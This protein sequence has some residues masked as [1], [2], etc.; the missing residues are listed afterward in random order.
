M[1][2]T[3]KELGLDKIISAKPCRVRDI[4]IAVIIARICRPDSKLAMTR[5]WEDTTLPE[6]LNLDG[7]IEG[8]IYEAMDWLLE[9][10][11]RIEK[12]LAK[13]HLK[14]GDMVLYDLTSSYFEGVNC[15]LAKM[16]K[17]RDRKRN[18]LQVNYGLVADRNGCPVSVS[19]FEGNTGDPTTL[20]EQAKKARDDLGIGEIVMVGD[21]GMITQKQIDELKEVDG[22]G[23]I[24][25]L[26]T[27]AI[28][29][30]MN[31]GALQLDL[32]DERGLF[33][34]THEDF[35]G[36]RLV[37]CR[38]PSLAK[39]RAHKRESMIEAISF[40]KSSLGSLKICLALFFTLLHRMF[41]RYLPVCD[42]REVATFSGVPQD[43]IRP[44]FSPPSGP[45]SITQS[46]HLITSRLCSITSTVFP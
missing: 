34:L 32:F 19:V 11:G 43:I 45:M 46:A 25:A 23:W 10:Q 28:R 12:K 2:K 31:A 20:M 22:M 14:E 15:P 21:R 42:F 36:E 35:P 4:I 41:F 9:R 5:W 27:G 30:L 24:T 1:L 26:K 39:K 8:H 40:A 37:A 29:K 18:T 44:P 7:V 38:N 3:V 33:E 6:L 13:R 16:G 17:S